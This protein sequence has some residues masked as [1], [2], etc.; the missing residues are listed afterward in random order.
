MKKINNIKICILKIDL[1]KNKLK[2]I[3]N[4]DKIKWVI[5]YMEQF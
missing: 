4:I 2:E 1:L 5:L 3:S